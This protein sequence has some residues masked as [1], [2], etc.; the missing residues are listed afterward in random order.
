MSGDWGPQMCPFLHTWC[1]QTSCILR[2]LSRAAGWEQLVESGPWK[3]DKPEH[4]RRLPLPYTAAPSLP[5][6]SLLFSN[7][8]PAR[9]KEPRVD[10]RPSSAWTP[11][12]P[13]LTRQGLL[14]KRQGQHRKTPGDLPRKHGSSPR[15]RGSRLLWKKVH[16]TQGVQDLTGLGGRGLSGLL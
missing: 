1:Q 3:R 13:A 10:P 9:G 8:P 12:S 15:Y 7:V 6:G 4:A 16:S 5:P 11:P 14:T 2:R